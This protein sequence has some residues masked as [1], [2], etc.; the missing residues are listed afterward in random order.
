MESRK[1]FIFIILSLFAISSCTYQSTEVDLIV[2][3]ATVYTV[4]DAFDKVEAFAVKD[5]KIVELGAERA[6]MNKYK[7]N[8]VINAE[9]KFVYP[10]FID[11][12]C[13][14]LAY[15]RGLTNV[16]LVGTTSWDEVVEKVV[17][18][19]KRNTEGILIGRG[20]DQNDWGQVDFP[21]ND[22]LNELFP[23]R[24]V[25]LSRIDGH[26]LIVNSKVLELANIQIGQQIDGGVIEVKDG[27]LTGILVDNAESLVFSVFPKESEEEVINGLLSAQDNCFEVG[28]TT[29]DDAGLSR[30]NIE[31]IARMQEEGK[32]KMRVYA[33]ISD[34]ADDLAYYFENGPIKTDRL[35][36]RSVKAYADGALGSRGASLLAPYAD[37]IDEWGFL[38]NSFDHFEELAQ[39]CYTHGFQMNTH[40]IGDS[41][42]RL[43]TDVY[44]NVLGG[45]NDLRWR[46]EHAQ[47]VHENDIRKFQDYSIIPSVQPTHATSDMYWAEDRLGAH[48]MDEAYPFQSLLSSNGMLA[49]GTDFPVEKIDPML[50]YYAAITRQDLDMYPEGGFIPEQ[51]LSRKEALR[52]MTIWAAI[53]NFEENEKGSLEINK[54]ADFVI[55][56]TDLL[57]AAEEKIPGAKVIATYIDGEAVYQK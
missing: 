15:G 44:A 31:I 45:T 48:R 38:V 51:R 20:W 17:E 8:K 56:D 10:G 9:K 34:N 53:A 30:S 6:I 3:N 37:K 13:H 7:A 27:K 29:V 55:M 43:L 47:I 40:C 19:S 42:N 2:H 16:D 46:I 14:F 35:N 49:L 18:Y 52:G 24:P 21:A 28:L 23:D 33:M 1:P 12:H 39:D 22:L 25:I 5:G 11:A 57:N 36:V 26:A 32:L 41:A 4:N 54:F 50:T